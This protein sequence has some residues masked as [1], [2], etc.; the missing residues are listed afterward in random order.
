MPENNKFK[1]KSLPLSD[2][3]R[4]KLL[5][6][7]EKELTN[8]ELLAILI[9][10]GSKEK[11]A[12]Q[13]AQE[14]MA[15]AGDDLNTLARFSLIQ[16]MNIKGMGQAKAITI[17]A[18]LE[19][20]NRRVDHTLTHHD[21]IDTSRKAFEF[22]KG[23][24]MDLTEEKFYVLFLNRANKVLDLLH[25]TTG[26]DGATVVDIKWIVRKVLEYRAYGIVVAHNHPSGH[27]RPGNEDVELTRKLKSALEFFDA[28]LHDHLIIHQ[29][30][31]FSFAE[32][33][34]L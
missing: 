10:T 18:A 17:K 15:L 23:K 30:S 2:R 7:G 20:S 22:M 25:H 11:S 29:H 33:G 13:L 1:V 24:F 27:L 8:S 9:N 34:I 26:S 12:I 14:I 3:P 32:N 21:I 19:L 6:K 5:Q 4:E 28:K 16:L 31:F